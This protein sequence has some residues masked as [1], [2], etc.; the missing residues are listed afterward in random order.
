M[1]QINRNYYFLGKKLK[2]LRLENHITLEE[3]S[4]RCSALDPVHAPSIAYL[5]MIESGKRNPSETVLGLFAQVFQRDVEW[6]LDKNKVF[7]LS[8]Q[9]QS[10]A[11]DSNVLNFEPNFLFSKR[12]LESAVPQLLQQSGVSTRQLAHILIRAHQEVLQNEYPELERVAEKVGGREFPL[13]VEQLMQLYKKHD[14]QIKWFDKSAVSSLNQHEPVQSLVR[15]FYEAPG[16]VYLN[17]S[18]QE[19]TARLKY[20]LALNLGHKVLHSGDGFKSIHASGGEPGESPD[21]SAEGRATEMGNEVLLAWRDF[22]C[23]YFAGALLCPKIPFRRFLTK[24]KYRILAGEKVDLSVAIVMRRMTKVSNYPHWHFF[25]AST[26]GKFRAIYRGNGIPLPWG[27]LTKPH[28]H[29]PQWAVF[30]AAGQSGKPSGSQISVIR[31]HGEWKIYCCHTLISPDLSRNSRIL[32]VGVDLG[33]ALIS[34]IK[35]GAQIIQDIG[36]SCQRAGGSTLLDKEHS[37]AIRAVA[38]ILNVAWIEEALDHPTRIICQS[39]SQCP[40]SVPCHPE[41]LSQWVH[42]SDMREGII[43][44]YQNKPQGIQAKLE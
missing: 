22:E 19:D 27:T 25:D 13:S 38:Q 37:D 23:S 12:I 3:L 5:S 33:P 1:V 16:T 20:D 35:N 15:S 2:T 11:T 28:D 14:L 24:E 9:S 39:D 31:Q 36:E 6:F 21:G 30:H 18:L 42:I 10:F 43:S 29:C 40:R 26:T 8:S 44:A 34:N 7:S 41:K 17:R 4:G 32:S